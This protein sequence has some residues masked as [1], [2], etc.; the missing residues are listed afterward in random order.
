M[1]SAGKKSFDSRRMISPT[2][3]LRHGLSS[4]VEPTRT[5]ALRELRSESDWW[6]F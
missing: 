1:R 2:R 3:M 5:L 4:N 6:R